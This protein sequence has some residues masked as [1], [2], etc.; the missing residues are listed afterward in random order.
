MLDAFRTLVRFGM[1]STDSFPSPGTGSTA[2]AT[3]A[4]AK[5][6]YASGEKGMW[7][8]Y[9]NWIAGTPAT[10][11]TLGNPSTVRPAAGAPAGCAT[12]SFMEVGARNQSAPPWEGRLVPFGDP[13]SDS[14]VA[15]TNDQI[16]MELLTMR[17]YG[18][19]PIAGLLDD[20]E[21][22]LF[23][24]TTTVPGHTYRFGPS[25]DDYWAKRLP[26]DVHH[27]APT[28]SPTS[29]CARPATTRA[30]AASVRDRRRLAP[31]TPI[32]R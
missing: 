2:A 8:Y 19:T 23:S 16:Q 1:M 5:A 25:D 11:S 18:A 21:E 28:A 9:H 31:P 13:D 7:S 12:P 24:D 4:T 29:I 14:N 27:P 3:P 22:F 10:P 15:T 6:D 30:S 26:Q 17:P 32:V 20:A